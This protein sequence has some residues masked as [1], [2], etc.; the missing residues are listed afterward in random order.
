MADKLKEE[1]IEITHVI[2]DL[3]GLL[4]GMYNNWI[5]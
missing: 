2:F 4:L 3:D 5:L 1:K